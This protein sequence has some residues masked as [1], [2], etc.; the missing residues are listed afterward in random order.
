MTARLVSATGTAGS[1]PTS[2]PLQPL[3]SDPPYLPP[4]DGQTGWAVSRGLNTDGHCGPAIPFSAN[5]DPVN[6]TAFFTE[7][8]LGQHPSVEYIILWGAVPANADPFAAKQ[9]CV[10]WG[11]DNPQFP[12]TPDAYGCGL[13]FVPGLACLTDNVNIGDAVMPMIPD[14]PPF[15]GNALSQYQGCQGQKAKVC[16]AQHG[17]TSGTGAAVGSLVYFTKIIDQ[18]DIGVRLP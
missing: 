3:S 6:R 8:S 18:S 1:A 4:T 14:A 11:V 16:I 5:F 15:Q 12:A 10:S 9:P 2:P 13:D 7:V 17:F